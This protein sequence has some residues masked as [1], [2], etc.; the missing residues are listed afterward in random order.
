MTLLKLAGGVI[1]PPTR[2]VFVHRSPIDSEK[3][4]WIFVAVVV[5]GIA[6]YEL[7]RRD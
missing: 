1:E 7:R 4:R 3:E 5:L 2:G 6:M